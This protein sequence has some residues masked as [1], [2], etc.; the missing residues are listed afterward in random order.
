MKEG[1]EGEGETKGAAEWSSIN[2]GELGSGREKRGGE[3]W[4]NGMT[5]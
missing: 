4:M 5:E 1:E 2:E 3:G